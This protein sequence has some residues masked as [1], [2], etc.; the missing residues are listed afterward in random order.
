MP[1][2]YVTFLL[3]VFLIGSFLLLRVQRETL[4]I[5]PGNVLSLNVLELFSKSVAAGPQPTV[6]PADEV[7]WYD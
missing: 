1:F 6:G 2:L 3:G 4:K 5:V 7:Y